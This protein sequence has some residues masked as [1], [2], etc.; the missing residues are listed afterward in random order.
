MQWR[1]PNTILSGL[2]NEGLDGPWA[3]VTYMHQ[4]LIRTH[5]VTCDILL[6]RKLSVRLC[7]AP[8]WDTNIKDPNTVF[9]EGVI[10]KWSKK[11]ANGQTQSEQS[12]QWYP[13]HRQAEQTRENT[14]NP[15]NQRTGTTSGDNHRHSSLW[16]WH[17]R[18]EKKASKLPCSTISKMRTPALDQS[19]P[20]LEDSPEP[21]YKQS[22]QRRP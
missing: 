8:H 3:L 7:Y 1:S 18:Q 4:Q 22:Y 20:Q 9:Y 15:R 16:L 13:E 5:H 14:T 6:H 2:R 17:R 11:Q 10:H 21:L 19:K 12:K